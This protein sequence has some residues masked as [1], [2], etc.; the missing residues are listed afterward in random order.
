MEA[1]TLLKNNGIEH[2]GNVKCKLQSKRN[3]NFDYNQLEKLKLERTG[4]S[5][6]PNYYHSICTKKN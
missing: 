6:I 5:I 2:K 4:L 3:D 1:I